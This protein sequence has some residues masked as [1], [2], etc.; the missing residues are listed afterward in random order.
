MTLDS[1]V[2]RKVDS[3]YFDYP[4]NILGLDYYEEDSAGEDE[5]SRKQV[6]FY[7]YGDDDIKQEFTN[8]FSE[9][10][11]IISGE[12]D[13]YWDLMTLMPSHAKGGYNNNMNELLEEVSSN[14]DIN[15]E[16]ILHRNHTVRDNHELDNLKEKV[17]NLESSID[18]QDSVEGK[19]IIIVDN[20]SLTGSTFLHAVELLKRNGANNVICMAL[21][22]DSRDRGEDMSFDSE[23]TDKILEELGIQED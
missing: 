23:S 21:G 17:I 18:I 15:F 20:I 10:L 2:Y 3:K 6:W 9:L 7:V 8:Q 1:F 12:D 22:I 4:A 16:R 14:V 19:N 13:D 5:F 11:N